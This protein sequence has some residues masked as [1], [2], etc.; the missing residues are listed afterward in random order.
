MARILVVEDSL[1][2][3]SNVERMLWEEGHEV[4][5]ARD[6]FKALAALRAF[7][8]EVIFL[9]IL[10]PHTDGFAICGII[11]RNPAYET[12][13][14][15]MMTGLTDEESVARAF[16]AGADAYIKKP[17]TQDQLI[18]EIGARVPTEARGGSFTSTGAGA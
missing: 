7:R 17:F 13:R 16:S 4:Y 9:D 3:I 15:V 8:P 12:V 11:R 1:T 2:L 14:V 6:G 18:A 10:L 5:T